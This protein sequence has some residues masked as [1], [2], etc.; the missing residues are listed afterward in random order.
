MWRCPA[1]SL[2]PIFFHVAGFTRILTAIHTTKLEAAYNRAE[3]AIQQ[4]IDLLPPNHYPAFSHSPSA[5]SSGLES[6]TTATIPSQALRPEV[7]AYGV[8]RD[9]ISKKSNLFQGK[10]EAIMAL[11]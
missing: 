1:A 4:V 9:R 5:G 2:V 11:S 3:K 8:G 7:L 10:I 6:N